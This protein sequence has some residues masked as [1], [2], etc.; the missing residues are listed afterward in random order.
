[1]L[2][3]FAAGG[4]TGI[5]EASPYE[6]RA[7]GDGA[8]DYPRVVAR[9]VEVLLRAGVSGPYALA[10]AP[11]GWT[12]IVESAERGGHLLLHHLRDIL[13]G[14]V[15]WAP[16]CSGGVVVSMRGG[17]FVFECGEDISVGYHD[18]D[19]TVARLYLE[20]SFSFRINSPDAAVALTA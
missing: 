2:H 19:A 10:I 11:D 14:P 12:R 16:G 13:G 5:V 3:G 9:A 7:V 1:V 20:E 6:P 15:V 8:D 17:D 18:H 4:I